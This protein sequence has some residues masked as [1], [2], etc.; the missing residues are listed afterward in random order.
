MIDSEGPGDPDDANQIGV[1]MGGSCP[2]C[3]APIDLGQ[4]FCLE[5]GSPIR[6]TP[7]QNRNPLQQPLAGATTTTTTPP[8]TPPPG[9]GGFPWV[10]FLIVVA[11]IGSG[12]A[13][14][15]AGGDDSG[16]SST[17]NTTEPA[18][19]TITNTIPETTSETTTLEDCDPTK[20]VS[21]TGAP[22][23]TT[24]AG[25]TFPDMTT[26]GSTGTDAITDPFADPTAT[27]STTTTT[28]TDT[29][30]S[31]GG[32][33]TATVDQNGVPCNSAPT[34]TATTDTRT[35]ATTAT[36]TTTPPPTAAGDWPSGT[37]GWT[38][39]VAGYDSQARAQQR[40]ADVQEDGYTDGGV[41]NSSDFASLC[42]GIWVAFSGTFDTE[43]QA[44]ARKRK[45]RATGSYPG[46]YVRHISTA[47]P[48]PADCST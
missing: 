31:T 14:A 26:D 13:F 6:F 39:V 3:R 43:A 23:T 2:V 4:E 22:S 19:P 28:A 11:L 17:T 18:L 12:I 30:G 38:V 36:T 34:S 10:P 16:A 44:E 1:G 40:A 29:T 5:C 21:S 33:G 35:T 45:L 41:L 7:R 27:T 42:P 24:T 32:S 47:G 25:E 37:D 46:T 8:A 15:M 9:R 48:A 20:P